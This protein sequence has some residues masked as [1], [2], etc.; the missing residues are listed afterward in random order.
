M[1]CGSGKF[2][3]AFGLVVACAGSVQAGE[4]SVTP[5]FSWLADHASN[6]A[7]RDGEPESQS[8]G[9]NL[10]VLVARR[11]ETTEFEMR[12]HYRLQRFFSDRYPDADDKALD[13]LARWQFENSA[14][15]VNAQAAEESTLTSELAETGLVRADSIRHTYSGG[16]GWHYD[17][18][19]NR[20]FSLSFSYQDVDYTGAYRDVLTGYRYASA[21][22]GESFSLSARAALL[23]NAFG[24]QLRNPERDST[25]DE[26]GASLGLRY[27]WTESTMMSLSLGL[28]RLDTQGRVSS[29]TTRDLSLEHKG[30]R[31]DWSVSYSHRL[32]PFGTG[33]LAERDTA[34]LQVVRAFGAR[35]STLLRGS[36]ARNEDGGFGLTFDRR[37]YRYGEAE[38]RWQMR[39]TWGTSLSTG[40]S[41]ARQGATF[42]SGAEQA[43]GWNVSLRTQW[44]PRPLVIGH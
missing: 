12:P 17:S 39:E 22:V 41:S 28:S 14:I 30:E 42:F 19:E 33:V 7:L 40:Y 31:L 11:D 16:F 4:W 32:Q 43:S 21:T 9:A 27:A 8:L 18:S 2:A 26:R 13:A 34:Q 10:D 20:Q 6:R 29:G 24:T 25:S 38:F 44:A 1:A 5:E 37:D 36:Y 23:V 3:L 35:F 15:D